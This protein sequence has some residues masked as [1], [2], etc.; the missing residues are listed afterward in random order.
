MLFK[1]A[2]SLYTS[3]VI[4]DTLGAED[5][6]IYNVVGGVVS[7]FIF[8]NGAM[9]ASTQRFLSYEIGKN[10]LKQLKKVF[11]ATVIIHLV[12]A[13]SIFLLAESIGVW[14]LNNYLNIPENRMQAAKWVYHLSALTIFISIIQTPYNAIIIAY[15][16]MNIYAYV[17][18]F[19]GVM[20]LVIVI[21]LTWVS[22]D[23]LKFYG[24]LLF[25]LNLVVAIFYR[26]YT[27]HQFKVTKFEVV[28]DKMLYKLL[29]SYSGWNLFGNLALVAKGQGTTILLNV[30]FGPVLNTAQAIAMQVNG[31]VQ[32]FYSN[33][34]TAL[35]PQIV[36]SYSA[37][38]KKYM[39]SL[40]IRG[41]KFSFYLIFILSLPI[42]LEIDTILG[43]WLVDVPEYASSFA[44]L[45]LII[46]LIDCISGPLITG[47]NATGN[48]RTFQIIVGSLQILILPM[49]YILFKLNYPPQA[50]YLFS[51]F[52]SIIALFIRLHIINFLIEEFSVKI[53]IKE[54]IYKNILIVC[55]SL[56]IPLI[57]KYFLNSSILNTFI[58]SIISVVS[59][60]VFIYKLG[61]EKGEKIMLNGE[62][63]KLL[64][65]IKIKS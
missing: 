60:G 45:I 25:I 54:V 48:I 35:N 2:L 18:V 41:A 42:L 22:F 36:K 46:A 37:N 40:I 61:L 13:L 49:S 1:M 17:S 51:M 47:V 43:I 14:V 38:D 11:N 59:C 58:I 62:I 53:F 10:D 6:G 24:T 56:V 63:Q 28:R 3:R 33:F 27:K 21:M 7:M 16:R 9:G 31:A 50:T 23:K 8:L 39:L 19:F 44:V 5:F 26:Y 20:N 65:K 55:L 32:G 12:I 34:Q 57:F 29:I 52:I 15:E 64:V 4:L 30:F